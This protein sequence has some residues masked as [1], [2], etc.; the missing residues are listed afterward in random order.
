MLL[1]PLVM[2][3]SQEADHRHIEIL[4]EVVRL[5]GHFS[6]GSAISLAHKSDSLPV[7]NDHGSSDLACCSVK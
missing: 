4:E 5:V 7:R 3:S 2:M 1:P 6:M